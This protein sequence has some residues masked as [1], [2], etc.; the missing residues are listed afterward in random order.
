MEIRSFQPRL[1]AHDR[2]LVAT[3]AL[4]VCAI[5]ALAV[6]GLFGRSVGMDAPLPM[7]VPLSAPAPVAAGF[8]DD[9]HIASCWVL[10]NVSEALTAPRSD[11]SSEIVG[12][13]YADACQAA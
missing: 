11:R 8:P 6:A 1:E 7:P 12:P 3:V 10:T 4:A 9:S 13:I 5:L 2:R